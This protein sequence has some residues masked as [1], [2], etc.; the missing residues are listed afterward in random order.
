MLEDLARTTTGWPARA[1]EYFE[2]LS[3]TQHVNHV[4]LGAPAMA[5]VRDAETMAMVDGPFDRTAHTVSRPAARLVPQR[6]QPSQHRPPRLAPRRLPAHRVP[7][8]APVADPPDGR[9]FVDPVG[10]DH[11]HGRP[12]RHRDRHRA[13]GPA[14]EHARAAAPA[15][16]PRRARRTPRRPR[17]GPPVVL[18]RRPGVHRVP[19]GRRRRAGRGRPR[20]ARGVRPL[21]LGAAHRH[22][23]CASTPCSAGSRSPPGGWSTALAVSWSYAFGADVGA[24]PY[25]GGRRLGEASRHHRLRLPTR[26]ECDRRPGAGRGRRHPGRSRRRLAR[27]GGD[28]RRSPRAQRAHRRDGQPPLRRGSHRGRRRR[29]DRRPGQPARDRRG[30][31]ARTGWWRA[32]PTGRGR[33][34]RG[35]ALPGGFARSGRHGYR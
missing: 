18:A 5:S 6:P 30:A 13:P 34:R 7:P 17:H 21:G 20:P 27:L 1:V 22:A 14:A 35:P 28:Q 33:S 9:W 11:A 25:R 4:R 24:G 10:N 29:G 3:T 26:S 19:A 12:P 15:P 2:L 32:P 16:A 23:W 8:A 31:L